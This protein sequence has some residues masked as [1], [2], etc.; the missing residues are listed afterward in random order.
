MLSIIMMILC[1]ANTK[2]TVIDTA[3]VDIKDNNYTNIDK[4][5]IE[6]LNAYKVYKNKYDDII[7][8]NGN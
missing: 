8:I 7:N 3:S 4:Y 5:V 6:T 1:A 2:T